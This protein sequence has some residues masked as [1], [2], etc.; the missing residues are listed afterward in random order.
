M[1]NIL[2]LTI[3]QLLLLSHSGVVSADQFSIRSLYKNLV[4]SV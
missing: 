3:A 2:K 4:P 1:K